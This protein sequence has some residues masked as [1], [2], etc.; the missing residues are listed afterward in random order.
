MEHIRQAASRRTIVLPQP[1]D[2]RFDPLI[3]QPPYLP[4]RLTQNLMSISIGPWRNEAAHSFRW[5]MGG[6]LTFPPVPTVVDHPAYQ[7][8]IP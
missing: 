8:H 6:F 3:Q 1:A 4:G 5:K 7:E 2:L